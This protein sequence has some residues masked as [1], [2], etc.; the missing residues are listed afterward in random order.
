MKSTLL[1]VTGLRLLNWETN[2]LLKVYRQSF[3]SGRDV[4]SSKHLLQRGFWIPTLALCKRVNTSKEIRKHLH[5]VK[6]GCIFDTANGKQQLYS[7]VLQFSEMLFYENM[8]V[9]LKIHSGGQVWAHPL[10]QW[11]PHFN[12]Y[13]KC[14]R[15]LKKWCCSYMEYF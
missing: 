3:K 4:F 9:I 12:Q 15:E 2:M 8:H 14:L 13:C 6:C 11:C 7:F 5:Q 1:Q 10:I